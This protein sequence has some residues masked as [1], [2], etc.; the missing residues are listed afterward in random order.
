ME[1]PDNQANLIVTGIGQAQGSIPA[2]V[3]PK[4]CILVGV[5]IDRPLS[6]RSKVARG[7]S[8]NSLPCDRI[9]SRQI[10]RKGIGS[11]CNIA[12]PA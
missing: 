8:R 3:H 2:P 6:V 11:I 7:R 1:V 10:E 12:N 5:E 4:G 9:G